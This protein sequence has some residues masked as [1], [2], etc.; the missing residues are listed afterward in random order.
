M[1]E[2]EI[3]EKCNDILDEDITIVEKMDKID[4]IDFGE[5]SNIA[6]FYDVDLEYELSRIFVDAILDRMRA[7][8]GHYYVRREDFGFSTETEYI[9]VEDIA[10]FGLWGKSITREK[11]F[12]NNKITFLSG[13]IFNVA[14]KDGDFIRI[15]KGFDDFQKRYKEISKEEFEKHLDCINEKFRKIEITKR[16]EPYIDEN[17]KKEIKAAQE[18]GWY[19]EIKFDF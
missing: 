5:N 17:D 16:E 12:F 8:I 2:N 11:G 7:L 3:E 4:A 19:N 6:A 15:E 18:K 14:S 13:Y 10:E 9:V 1:T